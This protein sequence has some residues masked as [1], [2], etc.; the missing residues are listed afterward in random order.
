MFLWE[1][2]GTSCWQV[3]TR[4]DQY[5]TQSAWPMARSVFILSLMLASVYLQNWANQK[6]NSL[7]VHSTLPLDAKATIVFIFSA[8]ASSFK[9]KCLQ[10]LTTCLLVSHCNTGLVS[11]TH[12]PEGSWYSTAPDT[13]HLLA[14]HKSSKYENR[15]GSQLVILELQRRSLLCSDSSRQQN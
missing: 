14:W 10:I 12:N 15:T 6:W 7:T 3:S 4:R 9:L 5:I 1:R 8:F 11:G 13:G 2:N